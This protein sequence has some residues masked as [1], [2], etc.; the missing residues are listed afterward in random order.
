MRVMRVTA[1]GGPEVLVAGEAPE[2]VAGPGQV[3]VEVGF[4]PVV[5][6]ETQLRQGRSPG[7]PLPTP[8]YVPGGGVA[9]TVVAVGEGVDPERIGARVVTRVLGGGCAQRA[10]AP[11][12]ALV[13]VPDG[14]G[15]DA[16]A[17]LLNDGATALGL[18]AAARVRP[19][20]WVLVEAAAG[21]VGSLLVQAARAAGARVVGAAR[22]GRKLEVVRGLGAD[23]AVDYSDP[24][25]A[26]QVRAVTGGAGADVVFDG[27]GGE[28]GR[29]A[30]GVTARGGRFSV[31]GA[32]GGP[33]T[34][35][36]PGEA[37]RRGVEFLG[38]EQLQGFDEETSR[39]WAGRAL[40][41][42]AAGRLRPVVGQ[43]FPLERAADAHAA[44]DDRDT[45]GRTLLSVSH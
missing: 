20:E 13:P 25:W 5:F 1:F 29:A 34:E 23:A 28:I 36:A 35:A 26:E 11:A 12:D 10:L 14:L 37:E 3:V 40:A 15:L 21:G 2:P 42:A 30:F 27:V 24:D 41:E 39:R 44:M 9:G 6:V 16:A 4:V 8:P 7:P 22:G 32:A 31:H 19:G 43:V 45:V 17:A 38:L 18:F 33:P